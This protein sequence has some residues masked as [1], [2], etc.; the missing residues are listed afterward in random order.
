MDRRWLLLA[1]PAAL[2]LVLLKPGEIVQ[3]G[4]FFEKEGLAIRGYDPVA[5][6]TQ[7]R[8]VKGKA[9]FTAT[10]KG[11]TFL[12]DSQANRALFIAD[13]ERYAPQ[14][15]GFCAYGAAQGYKAATDPAAFTIIGE[16]LYLNYSL[17]VQDRWRA[18][19]EG[20]ISKAN[21]IWPEVS[22]QDKV[23]E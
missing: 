1:A 9:E 21:G 23:A 5:Y 4:E 19:R 6:F 8:P 16:R 18:D 22:Q 15:G 2:A 10:F 17:P 3:A 14:Y 11:S 20:Y 12:F 13:P 7:N